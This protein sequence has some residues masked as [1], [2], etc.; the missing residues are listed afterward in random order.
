VRLAVVGA[1]IAGLTAAHRLRSALPQI[2]C[3]VY[4]R[5]AEIGGRVASR[6]RHGAIVDQGAQYLK[7]PSAELERFVTE[8]LDHSCLRDIGLP[9]WTFDGDGKTQPGDP[10]QNAD[11]KWTY[12]GGLAHLAQQLAAT[13]DLRLGT[14]VGRIVRDG[15][16]YLLFS[17][18]DALLSRAD[19]VLLTPPAPE[20]VALLERSTLETSRA[21]S[22]ITELRRAAY[23]P[24]LSVALGYPR[25]PRERPFYALVNT[26][27][28]HAISWL[29]YEHLKPERPMDG[30][31]VLIAQ[32]APGWSR[33]HWDE[34]P[35]A[36]E[37]LVAALV[38]GL[39]AE[40]LRRPAWHDDARWQFA[41]PDGSCR[42]DQ[43][44][45]NDGLFFAGDFLAGQGR[46]HLA[47]ESG[48]DAA[49]RIITA[50]TRTNRPS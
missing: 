8:A 4:E 6:Q 14:R 43:L 24:C 27:R 25:P 23:R 38:S 34:A 33:E 19:Y 47:L 26:D 22:L 40:D 37:G 7:T 1:G 17:D 32:M 36:I 12:T 30:Q 16:G 50:D 29:A 15:D 28:R 42:S 21:E 20:I 48:W 39:L 44:H 10:A 18:D 11:P 2:E 31:G 3:V 13:L 5:S 49:A 9:V 35:P 45:T 46:V 41:L